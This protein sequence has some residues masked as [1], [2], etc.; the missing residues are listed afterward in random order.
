MTL[1]EL[2]QLGGW[3]V[4]PLLVFSVAT[5]ALIIE[6]TI[7]IFFHN[8][9]VTETKEAI[10]SFLEQKDF[11]GAIEHCVGAK[12]RLISSKIFLTGLLVRSLGEHRIERSMETEASKRISGLESGFDLLIAI[13]SIAPITGFLGTVSGMIGAFQSI[14]TAA[15]VNAQLVAGGIFEALI[16]TAFG[17]IIAI[18]AI[19][20]YNIFAHI[21]DKFTKQLEE[22]G[23]EIVTQI[24]LLDQKENQ[25]V[26]VLS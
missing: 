23:A 8:L 22:A 20:A 12:K 6:R 10:L 24:L 17:L 15:D 7:Y 1:Q 19:T 25:K 9:R 11:N 5:V 26:G 4:W 18:A 21:V 13:G 16:T 14:A 2:L 3:A